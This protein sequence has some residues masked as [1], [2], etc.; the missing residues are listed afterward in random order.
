M[1]VVN[2]WKD[3]EPILESPTMIVLAMLTNFFAGCGAFYWLVSRPGDERFKRAEDLIRRMR[4]RENAMMARIS[5]LEVAKARL[6]ERL[7]AVEA[8]VP[9]AA[10]TPR[11]RKPR[12]QKD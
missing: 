5:E 12:V 2:R 3:I 9:A 8:R 11:A 10:P 6:E 1:V 4:D 7:S